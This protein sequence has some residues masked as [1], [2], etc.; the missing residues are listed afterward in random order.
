[1]ARRNKLLIGAA[2]TELSLEARD[3]VVHLHATQTRAGYFKEHVMIDMPHADAVRLYLWLG[4]V[5]GE[6]AA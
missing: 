1:M 3:D 4:E 2:K 5:V 6:V